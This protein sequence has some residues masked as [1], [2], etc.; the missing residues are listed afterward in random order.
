MNSKTVAYRRVSTE[1]QNT[2]RQLFETGINFDLEFED[3]LSGKN[4][5]N[6]EGLQACIKALHKGDTLYIHDIS[7]AGRNTEQVLAF[8]RELN[9]KGVTVKFY[10]ESLEFGGAGGDPIK[11]AIGQMVLTV[12]AACHTLFLTNNAT[13]TKEGL[14]RAKARGVKLGASNK[15]WQEANRDVVRKQNEKTRADATTHAETLRKEVEM[16]VSMKIP[17]H[18]MADKLKE[19]NLLTSKGKFYTAGSVRSLC[20]YLGLVGS[21]VDERYES[22]MQ[23]A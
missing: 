3:K 20:K 19:L 4:T 11:A 13:A 9:E 15:K 7:R 17:F 8:I 6:R 1:S 10:K 14:A 5:A 22:L 16:M 2:E 12:L 21:S 23:K 18:R